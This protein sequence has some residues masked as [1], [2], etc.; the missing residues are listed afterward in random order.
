MTVILEI[1]DE[2]SHRNLMRI[3]IRY[4][5]FFSLDSIYHD[6]LN[7]IRIS[8]ALRARND[9][10]ANGRQF[11]MAR[12]TDR[13]VLKSIKSFVFLVERIASI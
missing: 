6:Q 9:G 12:W 8:F 7:N 10:I 5:I 1:A 3:S 4:V 2:I 11:A 13:A